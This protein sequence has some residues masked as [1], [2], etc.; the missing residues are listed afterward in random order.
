MEASDAVLTSREKVPRRTGPDLTTGTSIRLTMPS[1]FPCYAEDRVRRTVLGT[2]LIDVHGTHNRKML[3]VIIT[4]SQYFVV[5]LIGKRRIR[6][7]GPTDRDVERSKRLVCTTW[8]REYRGGTLG[9]PSTAC[10]VWRCVPNFHRWSIVMRWRH[11]WK[12]S[13]CPAVP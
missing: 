7:P 9:T 2:M 11:G 5:L 10:C 6:M 1:V 3:R 12:S 13:R 8:A 4:A